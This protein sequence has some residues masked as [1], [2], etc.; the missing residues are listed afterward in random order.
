MRIETWN[1]PAWLE[2]FNNAKSV[3][4]GFTRPLLAQVFQDTVDIVNAGSY[5]TESGKIVAL[6]DES[7]MMQHTWV[8]STPFSADDIPALKEDTVVQV[9]NGD[10]LETAQQ[11]LAEGYRPAVLNLASAH[12]PGGGVVYGARAQEENLFR[13]SNQYRSMFRFSDTLAHQ[14]HVSYRHRFRYPMHPDYGGVYTPDVTVFRASEHKGYALL[15]EWYK[16]AFI[17]VAGIN[18]RGIIGDLTN[19]EIARTKNKIRTIF[20]IG[21]KKK[22]DSLVLG[23]LGCGAFHNPPRTIARLFHEVME[24]PEFKNKYR[25]LVFAIFDDH[26]APN[27]GNYKPFKEEFEEEYH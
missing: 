12:H 26:N 9:V 24:E 20:R 19:Q 5:Q 17:A 22:H 3:G 1:S 4:K 21:L 7:I 13:R 11:L 2:E 14:Y 23:A 25:R 10:C 18:R 15:D 27:G 6:P 8:C 16:M